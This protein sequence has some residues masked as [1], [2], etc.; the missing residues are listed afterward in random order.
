MQSKTKTNSYRSWN[1]YYNLSAKSARY[2]VLKY[3]F[4][5]LDMLVS[6][7]V[8]MVMNRVNRSATYEVL[9]MQL[10]TFMRQKMIGRSLFHIAFLIRTRS[11][12]ISLGPDNAFYTCLY[13]AN[14]FKKKF[15]YETNTYLTDLPK[16]KFTF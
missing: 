2:R 3:S 13:R 11:L 10:H 14:I 12:Y 9:S 16:L 8:P 5:S 7:W 4:D 1:V 15:S 6:F